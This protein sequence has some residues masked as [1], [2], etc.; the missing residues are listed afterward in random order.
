MKQI[1]KKIFI[2]IF[3]FSFSKSLI[4]FKFLLEEFLNVGF[5]NFKFL[6]K[7]EICIQKLCL[8]TFELNKNYFLKFHRNNLFLLKIFQ[9][10]TPFFY[11]KTKNWM[12]NFYKWMKIFGKF[13][14]KLLFFYKKAY[15]FL[16]NFFLF[17]SKINTVK[18]ELTRKYFPKKAIGFV[19]KMAFFYSEKKK[20]LSSEIDNFL[21]DFN[22]FNSKNFFPCKI[23]SI[24][25]FSYCG[26][27][28]YKKFLS[29]LK[30]FFSFVNEKQFLVKSELKFFE[31]T[32]ILSNGSIF[33]KQKVEFSS[34]QENSTSFRDYLF[35]ENI[36]F[37]KFYKKY[38]HY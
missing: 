37:F 3:K 5:K 22:L 8:N 7:N 4:I 29:P 38:H 28:I 1:E 13:V 12:L 36:F 15:D 11:R 20:I 14:L 10:F 32:R 25:L 27:K 30:F 23:Y 34:N 9:M 17:D 19:F 26:S 6:K 18:S 35:I 16:E 2:R 21:S 33:L 31:K 24:F